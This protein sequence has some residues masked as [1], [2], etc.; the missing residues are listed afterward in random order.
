MR[1]TQ[2]VKSTSDVGGYAPMEAA[3]AHARQLRS[4]ALKGYIESALLGVERGLA[5]LVDRARGAPHPERFVSK[6]R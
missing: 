2:R 1:S 6:L 5:A 4:Q 3:L